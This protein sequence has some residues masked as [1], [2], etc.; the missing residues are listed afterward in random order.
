MTSAWNQIYGLV[1]RIQH[2][3]LQSQDW[4]MAKDADQITVLLY[5]LAKEIRGEQ[6]D[7]GRDA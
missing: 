4:Q 7:S 6:P 5:H 1:G 3:A 2:R